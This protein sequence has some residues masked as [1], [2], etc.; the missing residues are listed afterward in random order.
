MGLFSWL[1][2]GEP[3]DNDNIEFQFVKLEKLAG[4][5]RWRMIWRTNPDTPWSA[6]ESRFISA[7]S[8]TAYEQALALNAE[9]TRQYNALLREEKARE[10]ERV[11]RARAKRDEEHRTGVGPQGH[12][13]GHWWNCPVCNPKKKDQKRK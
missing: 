8:Q 2:P 7:S 5:D 13:V 3:D 11:R 12:T 10:A 9:L 1:R 6:G 4:S